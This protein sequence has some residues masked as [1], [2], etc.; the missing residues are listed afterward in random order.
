MDEFYDSHTGVL[1]SVNTGD[2]LILMGNFNAKLGSDNTSENQIELIAISR[3]WQT[4][5]GCNC[6]VNALIANIR[7]KIVSSKRKRNFASIMQNT[8]DL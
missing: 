7:L 4:R 8:L 5:S 2:T 6:D 3:K 1:H